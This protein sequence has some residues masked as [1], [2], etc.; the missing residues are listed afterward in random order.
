V[1][2]IVLI[3]VVLYFVG[4]TVSLRRLSAAGWQNNQKKLEAYRNRLKEDKKLWKQYHATPV[5]P[6][7]EHQKIQR[8]CN[9]RGAAWYHDEFRY[10]ALYTSNVPVK[11]KINTP[12]KTVLSVLPSSLFW[13]PLWVGYQIEQG[14]N[15]VAYY[16]TS[17][18]KPERKQR[19]LDSLEK[20]QDQ[21]ERELKVG[22][23]AE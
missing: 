19:Q 15:G 3:L 2:L 10:S 1:T 21:L 23:Y 16:L 20:K 11:P 14:L 6:I 4:A 17:P 22:P 13:L 8:E 7:K 9:A 12:G 18:T 5:T